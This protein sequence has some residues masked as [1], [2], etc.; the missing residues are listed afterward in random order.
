MSLGLCA[1][2]RGGKGPR[3]KA[4]RTEQRAGKDVHAVEGAGAAAGG[5]ILILQLCDMGCQLLQSRP[6]R[7]VELEHFQRA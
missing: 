7:E 2:E 4:S 3:K 6:P 5:S 1:G